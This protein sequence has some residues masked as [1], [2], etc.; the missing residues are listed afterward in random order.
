MERYKYEISGYYIVTP[1]NHEGGDRVH[2]EQYIEAVDNIEA[3]KIAL[4]DIM[5]KESLRNEAEF[6]VRLDCIHY[7]CL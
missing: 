1:G 2:F 6:F 4:G 3:M 7:E 5:W